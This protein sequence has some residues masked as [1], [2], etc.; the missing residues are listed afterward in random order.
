[1]C[2]ASWVRSSEYGGVSGWISTMGCDAELETMASAHLCP[3]RETI[4]M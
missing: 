3:I 1:V 2:V 4:D